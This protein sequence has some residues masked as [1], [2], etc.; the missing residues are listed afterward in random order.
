MSLKF[1]A[2]RLLASIDHLQRAD[3]GRAERWLF[4]ERDKFLAGNSE[5]ARLADDIAERSCVSPSDPELPRLWA[6]MAEMNPALFGSSQ[7]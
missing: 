6:R 2:K 1:R 7:A 5:A 3:T 4:A